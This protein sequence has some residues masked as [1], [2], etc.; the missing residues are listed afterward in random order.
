LGDGTVSSFNA[1]LWLLLIVVPAALLLGGLRL[2][3]LGRIGLAN[4][5]LALLAVPGLLAGGWM[6]LLI[7]LYATHPGSYR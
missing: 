4:L 3:A 1:A 6:L 5:L 2:K 7:V